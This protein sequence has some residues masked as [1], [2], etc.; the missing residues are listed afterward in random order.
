[1]S[2]LTCEVL[3]GGEHG[4]AA[5]VF[6]RDCGVSAGMAWRELTPR[7]KKTLT[8]LRRK[9]G[10]K[11][12]AAARFA[13]IGV[14]TAVNPTTRNSRNVA[15]LGEIWSNW[16]VEK[17]EEL[18]ADLET[19]GGEARRKGEGAR[20]SW[21]SRRQWRRRFHLA[22]RERVDGRWLSA[23][24]RGVHDDADSLTGGAN[25]GVRAPTGGQMSRWATTTAS[26]ALKRTTRSLTDRATW[27]K[28]I[29]QTKAS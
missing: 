12:G 8:R 19:L 7:P 18:E 28:I 1:M 17:M 2:L 26:S 20:S 4:V 10:G 27:T 14:M 5:A 21:S 24:C 6:P 9:K 29:F 23:G 11:N 15:H 22:G 25:T 3:V 16:V 13:E